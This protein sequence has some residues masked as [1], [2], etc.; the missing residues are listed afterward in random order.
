MVHCCFTIA[1]ALISNSLYAETPTLAEHFMTIPPAMAAA[2]LPLTPGGV[3][4]QEM[5]IDNLFREL[6]KLPAA[7]SGLIVASVFRG[8]LIVVTLLGAVYYFT[9]IGKR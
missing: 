4:V 3:G 1:C 2:T 5:A 9:G 6:P 7:F 8:L